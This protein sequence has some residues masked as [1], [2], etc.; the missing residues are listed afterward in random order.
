MSGLFEFI[1]VFSS[2]SLLFGGIYM[3]KPV[4]NLAKTVKY[5]F[6]LILICIVL[7]AVLN[8]KLQD[9]NSIATI[10]SAET[11]T[12]S[13]TNEAVRLTFI[14]ALRSQDINFYEIT[15]C[16]NKNADGSIS[17]SKVTIYSDESKEKI[18]KALSLEDADYE[19]EVCY[20]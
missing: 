3:L 6:S 5:V 12:Y 4:G 7:T 18:I 14:E 10:S 20:E 13:L 19:I 2:F 17:I 16:T 1:T 15:V 8:I 9:F 11:S